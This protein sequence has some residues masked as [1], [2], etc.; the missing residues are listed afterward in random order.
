[1]SSS[2]SDDDNAIYAKP[3]DRVATFHPWKGDGSL[4][5]RLVCAGFFC[6]GEGGDDETT[7]VH[8]GMVC[9]EWS[10]EDDPHSYAY[11]KRHCIGTLPFF[12]DDNCGVTEQERKRIEAL[13]S[14]EREQLI[15]ERQVLIRNAT[16]RHNAVRTAWKTKGNKKKRSNATENEPPVAKRLKSDAPKKSEA[17]SKEIESNELKL[18]AQFKEIESKFNAIEAKLEAQFKVIESALVAV[19][20]KIEEGCKAMESRLDAEHRVNHEIR[21][22]LAKH[23]EILDVVTSTQHNIIN[24]INDIENKAKEDAVNA[25]TLVEDHAKQVNLADRLSI[26]KLEAKQVDQSSKLAMLGVSVATLVDKMNEATAERKRL[27]TSQRALATWTKSSCDQVLAHVKPLTALNGALRAVYSPARSSASA[28]AL[29]PPPKTK[30]PAPAPVP[31]VSSRS[32]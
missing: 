31:L 30:R 18:E 16:D 24:R 27:E 10:I 13:S 20:S 29:M 9:C 19:E 1:M 8:C 4:I 3:E 5:E 28:S 14:R 2:S 21:D 15:Y 32:S 25:A 26:A 12:G 22:K 23:I 7:C 6:S 11:H 17:Q